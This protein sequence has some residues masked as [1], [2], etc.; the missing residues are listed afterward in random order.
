M[1]IQDTKAARTAHVA[2]A[3]EQIRAIEAEGVTP[4]NLVRMC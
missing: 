1:N 2:T 3:I 4:E